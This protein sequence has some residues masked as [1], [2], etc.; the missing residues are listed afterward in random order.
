[1]SNTPNNDQDRI[2]QSILDWP[3]SVSAANLEGEW[4]NAVSI[5]I[6]TFERPRCVY[7]L[8]K[9]IRRYYPTIPVLVCD[10]SKFPL[11]ENKQELP[12]NIRWF[13]LPY[14]NGHTLGASRNHL[15]KQLQSKYFFLCDDDHVFNPHT[16]LYRMH[17][18]LVESHFDIVG[19]CQGKN[20][21]G[22]AIF[23]QIDDIVYQ[24]FYEH[25]GLIEKG[26]VHCDRVSNT[27]MAK[28]DSVL[29][30]LWEDR[31]YGSEHAE[32]FLRA[33]RLGT[34]V[35]QMNRTYV[36]HERECES[37]AGI[38]GKL[39]GWAL[40]HRDREYNLFR[41]GADNIMGQDPKILEQKYCWEKNDISKIVSVTSHMKKR[42]FKKLMCDHI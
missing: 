38:I 12:E 6:S 28:T 14:E 29:Q 1:M 30:V 26:I 39:F 7:N 8:L 5:I 27:F 15:V 19:G 24:H 40:S 13:T 25:H 18:F 21:Y 37:A 17:N 2:R 20:D 41:N 11:F 42:S 33:A 22:T 34:K 16:D 3:V 35:A 4:S 10:S 32:F 31:V 36:D 9:S 23:K